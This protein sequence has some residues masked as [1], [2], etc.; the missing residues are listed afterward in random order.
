[1]CAPVALGVA[2]AASGA[3]GAIGQHQS[4]SAQASAQNAAA[5][6]NYKYQLKVRRRNWDQTRHIYGRKIA[7]FEEQVNENR[8]AAARGY[9]A[10]Q[11]G[12]NEKFK[13]AA[14]S[15]ESRLAKLV[16]SQGNFAAAG[17]QGR[18]TDRLEMEQLMQFGR[19]R[20]AIG[21]GLMSASTAFNSNV[22][23]LRREQLSANRKAYEN[24]AIRP[25]PT[26]APAQ[27]TM[28]PGPS[29]LSLASGL[30]GAASKGFSTYDSLT[31]GGAFGQRGD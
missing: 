5:T 28:M 13:Q 25:M 31:P 1:M 26:V 22:E 12:M 10:A 30:I 19:G 11:R 3:M 9:A 29:G 21:E 4:A 23:G 18:S 27:P 8:L 16:R 17:R 2:A 6:N 14:F 24:V 7:Q 20:A 15:N